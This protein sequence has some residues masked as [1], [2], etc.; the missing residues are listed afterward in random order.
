[1]PV[2]APTFSV[3][4][5]YYKGHDVI[6]TAVESVLAQT[7]PP[8]EIV[9]C[10]D[11]SPDDLEAALGPLASEVRIVRKENGGISSA[12]NT[13]ADAA[14]GEF[15]VQLDQDD[16]FM[17]RRLEAIAGVIADHPD[18]DVVATDAVIEFGGTRLTLLSDVYPFHETGQRKAILRGLFFL[19][20]TVRRSRLDAI[21]GYDETFPVN[22]DWECYVRLVL[23]GAKVAFVPEALYAWRLT[24]G[25]RSSSDAVERATMMLRMA[26]KTLARDDLD[27]EERAIAEA[28]RT[29]HLAMLA[30]ERAHHALMTAGK[31]QRQ[32]ALPL[33]TRPGF[34]P[35]TR[36]K[37]ALTLLSPMLA[38]RF[39]TRR[40]IRD[41]ATEA[42]VRRHLPRTAAGPQSTRP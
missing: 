7:V 2:P 32:L 21:G 31:D 41:P 9:I 15:V 12:M 22:H 24:P 20:P 26:D 18:A 42:L 17:P 23:S 35:M 6:R 30:I 40:A 28:G 13:A 3:I 8:H 4:I 34:R 36:A 39:I 29:S 25:S 27:P 1:M 14:T 37:A 16:V 38:R 19:W 10:D 11:G 5:P 33:L